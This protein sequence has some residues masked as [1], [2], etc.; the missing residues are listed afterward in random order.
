MSRSLIVKWLYVLALLLFFSC[1]KKDSA[2]SVALV[3]YEVSGTNVNSLTITY[4]NATG[5]EPSGQ[6]NATSWMQDIPVNRPFTAYLK[7]IGSKPSG[8]V[9]AASVKVEIFVDGVSKSVVLV[10]LPATTA[11]SNIE[12]MTTFTVN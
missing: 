5:S 7:A 11:Q 9:A 12:A 3:R 4:R 1:N 8:L 2:P 6:V 10:P